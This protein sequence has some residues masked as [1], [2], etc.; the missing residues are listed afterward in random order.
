MSKAPKNIEKILLVVGVL[1]GAGLGYLGF[2]Q[3]GRADEEF[4]SPAPSPDDSNVEVPGAAEVPGAINSFQSNRTLE[5]GDVP[6]DRL[7]SGRREVGLFVGVPLYVRE[8]KTD[9]PFDLLRSEDLHPPI[10]NQWWLKYA[11][12]PD[13]DDS[14]QRDADDDGFS[15]LAEFE[16]GTEPNNPKSHPNLA[17]ALAYAGD[18]SRGWFLKFGFESKDN[19]TWSPSIYEVEDGV[20]GRRA[21][22]LSIN[23]VAPG[24]TLFDK[25]D[26]KDRFKFLKIEDRTQVRQT[27]GL[28]QQLR[29]ASFED[30][31]ENKKGTVYEIPDKIYDVDESHYYRFD[32]TA[33][34]DLR[35]IGQDGKIFKVEENT[36]FALPPDAPEKNY[37]LK[38]VTP[39][40]VE[41]EWQDGGE[42]K[43]RVI[44]KD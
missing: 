34:L 17:L 26:F 20:R 38:R 3:L 22:S 44:P 21:G 2:S 43:S 42:T 29:I 27:T 37:L 39:E 19:G 18:E 25:G 10:P 24:G 16:A 28:E 8:G 40:E 41:I 15:N 7:E 23:P 5:S 30:L 4:G 33:L 9:D 14:P 6:S 1:A 35:A 12:S 11:V 36:R 13:F 31:K 32:R